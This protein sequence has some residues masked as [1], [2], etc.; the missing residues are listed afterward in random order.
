M[1]DHYDQREALYALYAGKAFPDPVSPLTSR[2]RVAT[3]L[4]QF[5]SAVGASVWRPTTEH[6]CDSLAYLVTAKNKY[7]AWREPISAFMDAT[8]VWRVLG[9][10]DGMTRLSFSPTYFMDLP[11][12][13]GETQGEKDE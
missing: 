11:P 7:G 2:E 9:S 8:G 3:T 1:S 12:K 13:P 5:S 6:Q 4:K 10:R